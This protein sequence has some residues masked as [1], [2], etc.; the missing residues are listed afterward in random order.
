[1]KK[2][3]HKV[4]MA[5]LLLAFAAGIILEVMPPG[6]TARPA[7]ERRIV[8]GVDCWIIYVCEDHQQTAQIKPGACTACAK[9][10]VAAAVPVNDATPQQQ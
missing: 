7:P 10:L 4:I 8:E 5:G 9:P 3:L 1:M 6:S 2:N